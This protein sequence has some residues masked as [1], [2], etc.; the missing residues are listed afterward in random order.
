MPDN[1]VAQRQA[2][3][4]SSTGGR[5][6]VSPVDSKSHLCGQASFARR[7]AEP[8]QPLQDLFEPSQILLELIA[9][10]S[11]NFT[12]PNMKPNLQGLISDLVPRLAGWWQYFE[13][14]KPEGWERV[15]LALTH[16]G[17]NLEHLQTQLQETPDKEL[18]SVCGTTFSALRANV[19]TLLRLKDQFALPERAHRSGLK[20]Q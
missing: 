20:I 4:I 2:N 12:S 3:V 17:K 1:T 15:H 7:L 18:L 11:L 13:E 8:Q 9:P 16:C 5:L 6:P 19:I 14:N 10:E